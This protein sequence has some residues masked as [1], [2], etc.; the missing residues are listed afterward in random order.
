MGTLIPL[1]ALLGLVLIWLAG[2]GQAQSGMPR[3]RVVYLDPG[4]LGPAPDPL[5]DAKL[6]LAGRPDFLL[7]T[8]E[9]VIPVEV[10]SGRAPLQPH[11]SHLLQLAAYCR[12]VQA[13][14]DRRPPHGV[15]KY[16]DRSLA[17][18]FSASLEERLLDTLAEMRRAEVRTPDRSHESAGRCRACGYREGCDQR[19]G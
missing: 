8:A 17:V 18:P 10:K 11:D 15:L 6:D 2:R 16:A 13:R 12:L 7:S 19:L 1:L 5:Y 3:G 14:E 4:S 9:G